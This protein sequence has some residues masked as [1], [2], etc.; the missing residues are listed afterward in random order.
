[1]TTGD[2]P[3][4]GFIQVKIDSD[5]SVGTK[6]TID[7][8][9]GKGLP[10]VHIPADGRQSQ[11]RNPSVFRELTQVP[12]PDQVIRSMAITVLRIISINT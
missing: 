10:V 3:L 7:R 6:T 8:Q 4:E 9:V 1:V 5:R 11:V 2:S 12:E